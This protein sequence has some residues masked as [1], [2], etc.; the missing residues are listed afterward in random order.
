VRSYFS[1]GFEQ[2]S[3]DYFYTRDH[4][5][6]VREVVASD[7][8]TVGARLSYD[9]WG[10]VTETGSVLIDLTYTGHYYDRPT[11]LSLAWYRGYDPNL[12]RWL[13]KDPIG[14]QGG[15]NLYGYVSN[16]PIDAVDPSGMNLQSF[17]ECLASGLSSGLCTSDELDNV[18]DGLDKLCKGP[19]A[20]LCGPGPLMCPENKSDKRRCPPC[21]PP[22][23]P[24]FHKVPPHDKHWPCPGD[25]MHPFEVN[26]NSK[27]ECFEKK[28][29]KAICL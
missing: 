29:K 5:G 19:L 21:P 26:Q 13:S 18:S 3:D 20:F 7:G 27:C 6:S 11:G 22:S 17:A 25:H 8:A 15:L 24:M 16:D 12:G 28:S 23:P 10:T 14:L 9:P 1:Q 4:L 2:G